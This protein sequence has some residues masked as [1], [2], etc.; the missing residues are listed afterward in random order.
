[1]SWGD[2]GA[3]R[4]DEELG[5]RSISVCI[6]HSEDTFP[7]GNSPLCSLFWA[8]WIQAN[9]PGDLRAC[10]WSRQ[11]ISYPTKP[12]K[13]ASRRCPS[14]A[15]LPGLAGSAALRRQDIAEGC[16]DRTWPLARN[17]VEQPG[18]GA[19]QPGAHPSVPS[20]GMPSPTKARPSYLR[21][22]QGLRTRSLSIEP[23]LAVSRL[24]PS[25]LVL[26]P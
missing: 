11:R 10:W 7:L 1:V 8:I 18:A 3:A 13:P 19:A 14:P 16:G 15:R 9:L 4:G 22:R 2:T 6:L 17:E 21:E 12:A 23:G 20:G 24:A 25:W 26:H 5:T